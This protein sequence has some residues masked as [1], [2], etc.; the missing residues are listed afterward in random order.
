[1]LNLNLKK[2]VCAPVDTSPVNHYHC[3]VSLNLVRISD[4]LVP[5]L[6]QGIRRIGDQLSQ[7]DLLVGVERVDDKTLRG[8]T[9]G[10]LSQ[11]WGKWLMSQTNHPIEWCMSS[12][13]ILKSFQET[14]CSNS[15]VPL[16]SWGWDSSTAGCRHWRQKS[17]PWLPKCYQ[18]RGFMFSFFALSPLQYTHLSHQRQIAR[19][20]RPLELRWMGMSGLVH[21]AVLPMS[22]VHR[23]VFKLQELANSKW[24]SKQWSKWSVKLPHAPIPFRCSDPGLGHLV[25]SRPPLFGTSRAFASATARL[26]PWA[27]ACCKWHI[28]GIF[29]YIGYIGQNHKIGR[30][31]DLWLMCYSNVPYTA[32]GI[33]F[34]TEVVWKWCH[35]LT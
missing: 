26:T 20:T 5:D 22:H 30:T 7:K 13:Q 27:Q 35:V 2:G 32:Y 24:L 1:M 3:H 29:S 10:R 8:C 16:P 4:G 14:C 23:H 21:A 6:V 15:T 28:S 19:V 31:Y 18:V 33:L 25:S 9:I 12:G 17:L 11:I 34:R